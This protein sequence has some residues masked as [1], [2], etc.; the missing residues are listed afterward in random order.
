MRIEQLEYIAAVTEYGSL[1]RASEHLHVSQPALSEAVTK[2]ERELGVTLL[3]RHRSGARISAAGRELLAGMVDVLEAVDRLRSA[4]GDQLAVGRTLRVG[5]VNAGTATLLLPAIHALRTERPQAS[6]EIRTLQQDEINVGLLEQ[7]L[8]LG[9]VNLLGGDDLPPELT[10]TVLLHGRPIAV[11]PRDHPLAAK[12]EVSADDLRSEPFVAM[13]AGYLMHRFAHRLFGSDLPR[14]W[15]V[16][17]GAEMGKLMVA[18][19]LGLTVLPD[20]SVI[21]DPLERTGLITA[22]PI[23]DNRTRI[24]L[25]VVQRRQNRTPDAV[26]RLVAALVAQAALAQTAQET[27]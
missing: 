5:S 23:T 11:L 19:G 25:A 1:R 13:R 21:G 15:H 8:D 16:T 27:G 9:L 26:R 14:A 10:G 2:L 18:E 20:Y 12:A 17:D 4:A 24:R 7:T 3:D 22:R 6:V